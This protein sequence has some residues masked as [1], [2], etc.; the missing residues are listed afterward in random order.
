[1]ARQRDF[2]PAAKRQAVQRGDHGLAAGFDGAEGFVQREAGVEQR[3]Q[4]GFAAGATA[5]AAGAEFAQISAG[6]EAAGFAA[7]ENGAFDG[8][9]GVQARGDFAELADDF[10]GERVHGAARHVERDQGN[11]GFVY[12][13]REVVHLSCPS[14]GRPRAPPLDPAGA[15]RP[16]TP[17]T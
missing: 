16:Q 7:G 14:E 3:A 11:A 10:A 9:I 12:G 4:P 15:S 8:G 6:A 5:H 17:K 2:Q 13:D 1:M